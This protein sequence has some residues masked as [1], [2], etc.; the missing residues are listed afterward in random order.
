MNDYIRWWNNEERKW[1]YEH[2]VVMEEFLG[3]RLTSEEHVHHVD[4]DITNNDISNLKIVSRSEHIRI[5]KPAKKESER[6]CFIEGCLKKHHAKGFCK[7]H[8]AREYPAKQYGKSYT[9]W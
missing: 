9:G 8:Y 2:R 7:I 1:E 3:R 6:K 4:E 5:H